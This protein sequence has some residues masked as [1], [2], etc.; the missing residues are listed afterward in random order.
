MS[1]PD[2]SKLPGP[3]KTPTQRGHRLLPST[4]HPEDIDGLANF[5]QAITHP[6][7]SG[8]W[9]GARCEC[10][11]NPADETPEAWEQRIFNCLWGQLRADIGPR[12]DKD[13]SSQDFLPDFGFSSTL[14]YNDEAYED[15]EIYDGDSTEIEARAYE[16]EP[17]R[18]EEV[19]DSGEPHEEGL[20]G[21]ADAE[22]EGFQKSITLEGQSDGSSGLPDLSSRTSDGL[23]EEASDFSNPPER[24]AVEPEASTDKDQ[25]ESI[26][27]GLFRG[28]YERAIHYI[29]KEKQKAKTEAAHSQPKSN[30][31]NGARASVRPS[32]QAND[33]GPAAQPSMPRLQGSTQREFF[34]FRQGSKRR[35]GEDPRKRKR[36]PELE[37]DLED[38]DDYK[39]PS[40]KD[41]G[42]FSGFA[43]CPPHNFSKNN[44][45]RDVKMAKKKAR[46]APATT[47]G[48][49]ERIPRST[50]PKS[51]GD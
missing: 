46:R 17:V 39:P 34:T 6:S 50:W 49:V 48:T 13:L 47:Q 23:D 25:L 12:N 26:A 24:N 11:F 43:E 44:S 33:P 4:V 35:N 20:G 41:K 2:P 15:G 7:T 37:E 10:P 40:K 27:N 16:Y 31:G 21:L 8:C 22:A 32:I 9:G 5:A 30:T 1:T 14:T 38:E 36:A 29:E 28:S 3:P 19:D 51:E 42:K 18:E 45:G